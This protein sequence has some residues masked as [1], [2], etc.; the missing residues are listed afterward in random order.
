ME[1]GWKAFGK[2]FP[3]YFR[4]IFVVLEIEK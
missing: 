4:W 3:I 1:I 2:E